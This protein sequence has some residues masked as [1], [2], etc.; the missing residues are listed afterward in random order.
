MLSYKCFVLQQG[1]H[2][3]EVPRKTQYTETYFCKESC[4]YIL[5]HDVFYMNQCTECITISRSFRLKFVMTISRI[6]MQTHV[7]V[8]IYIF[9]MWT[10]NH[11]NIILCVYVRSIFNWNVDCCWCMDCILM[12]WGNRF[13][14]SRHNVCQVQKNKLPLFWAWKVGLLHLHSLLHFILSFSLF[15]LL[16]QRQKGKNVV[17]WFVLGN[18]LP[19]HPRFKQCMFSLEKKNALYYIF[20][21]ICP[22]TFAL[23]FLL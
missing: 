22:H 5:N 14:D 6:R 20:P 2:T 16:K 11:A 17:V 15:T 13:A 18:S 4:S 8:G 12:M 3:N 21:F 10:A 7:Y 23:A 19:S 1:H 9:L